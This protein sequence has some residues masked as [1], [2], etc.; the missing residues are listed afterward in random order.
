M[1]KYTDEDI[2]QALLAT[3]TKRKAAA[4]IGMSERQLYERVKKDEFQEQY[5][6]A[7]K[8][9]LSGATATL[10]SKLSEA[11]GVLV[12]VMTDRQTAA[13]TRVN[14]A[15]NVIQLCLKLTD[16]VDITERI[17]ALEDIQNT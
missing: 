5:K 1:K 6:G 15:T 17:Q 13:Q 4:L 7:R 10:Q 9:L 14:A 2:I 3:G 11:T 12:E 16:T 8:E